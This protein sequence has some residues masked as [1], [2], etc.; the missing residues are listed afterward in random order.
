MHAICVQNTFYLLAKHWVDVPCVYNNWYCAVMKILVKQNIKMWEFL[1]YTCTTLLSVI[2]MSIPQAC[3]YNVMMFFIGRFG[4]TVWYTHALTSSCTYAYIHVR[5][6]CTH[7]ALSLH[8]G[9]WGLLCVGIFSRGCLIQELYE[10]LCYCVTSDLPS[11]V[12]R[13]LLYRHCTCTLYT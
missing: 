5:V 12:V 1:L 7:H 3:H 10:D 2:R 9:F 13:T 11:S 4:H 8:S 6:Y